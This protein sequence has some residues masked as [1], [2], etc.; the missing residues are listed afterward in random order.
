MESSAAEGGNKE[1]RRN[2]SGPSEPTQ[3][4]ALEETRP[5]YI[6]TEEQGAINK[7]PREAQLHTD[8]WG[9][10]W[11]GRTLRA[12]VIFRPNIFRLLLSALCCKNI[13]D[14]GPSTAKVAHSGVLQYKNSLVW[15]LSTARGPLPGG[16]VLQKHLSIQELRAAEH[17]LGSLEAACCK[18]VVCWEISCCK[19]PQQEASP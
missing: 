1:R 18:H 7:E 12:R 6:T 16:P 14:Q 15:G 4:G 2:S 19:N 13:P 10:R 5:K 11:A 8:L 9:C 17:C 3:W